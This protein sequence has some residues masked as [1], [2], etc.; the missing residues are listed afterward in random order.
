MSKPRQRVDAVEIGR[1]TSFKHLPEVIYSNRIDPVIEACAGKRV[2]NVGCAGSNALTSMDPVHGQIAGVSSSCLGIDLYEAG[3]A[4]FRS[5]GFDVE[6]VNAESFSRGRRPSFEI[7]VL[8]DV[9]EHL[10]NPGLVLDRVNES[11]GEDGMVVV[12]TPNPFSLTLMLGKLVSRNNGVNSDHVTWYDLVVL[13]E[14]LRRSGFE[15][16]TVYWIGG[17]RIPF[18]RPLLRL[19]PSLRPEF[20][21]LARK[22]NDI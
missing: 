15:I 6:F 14:L 22:Y 21:V 5:R 4:H 18:L 10:S 12:T 16:T 19:I 13:S 3:V 8:G 1:L 17:T 2:L 9:I 20:G 7:A 11:L